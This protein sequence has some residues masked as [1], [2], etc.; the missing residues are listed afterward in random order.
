MKKVVE[1][2][3]PSGMIGVGQGD[4]RCHPVG[5]RRSVAILGDSLIAAR[6]LIAEDP[7]GQ[8]DIS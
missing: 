1:Q 6:A 2:Q 3:D 7:I 8:R 4:E 5:H